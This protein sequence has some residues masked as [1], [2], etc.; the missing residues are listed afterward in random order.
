MQ[1][2]PLLLT[3]LGLIV[4]KQSSS[5]IFTKQFECCDMNFKILVTEEQFEQML[6][7]AGKSMKREGKILSVRKVS[8]DGDVVL[9][10]TLRQEYPFE[11]PRGETVVDV[12]YDGENTLYLALASSYRNAFGIVLIDLLTEAEPIP[13]ELDARSIEPVAVESKKPPIS[14]LPN[15]LLAK[16]KNVSKIKVTPLLNGLIV[17]IK[18]KYDKTQNLK[19]DSLERHWSLLD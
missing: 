6:N 8:D 3:L 16:L 10:N 4:V 2:I 12:G 14:A 9:W 1:K 18:D 11:P 15:E 19:Y 5:Q 13:I 7:F 17:E